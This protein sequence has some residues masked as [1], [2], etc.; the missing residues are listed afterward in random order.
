MPSNIKDVADTKDEMLHACMLRFMSAHNA[1]NVYTT[2]IV[3]TLFAI[4]APQVE[5]PACHVLKLKWWHVEVG[6]F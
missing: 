6:T 2:S 1:Y 4:N 3:C 5:V